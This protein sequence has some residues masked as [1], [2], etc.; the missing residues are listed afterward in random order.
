MKWI[1]I[2]NVEY[3]ECIVLGGKNSILMNDCGSMS[4]K[5]HGS[6]VIIDDS[7]ASIANRYENYQDKFFILTHY[8]KDH[9]CGMS[10]ICV[11][12]SGYFNRVFIPSMPCDERG[13]AVLLDYAIY[14]YIFMPYQSDSS[15][16]NTSCVRIF[17][18][19]SK[20]AGAERIFTL[21]RGDNFTFDGTG[22]EVL[23]PLDEKYEF[24]SELCEATEKLNL[25]FAS[26]YL[27]GPAKNFLGI[28]NRYVA[29]Y[30]KCCKAF[31]V[32][33]RLPVEARRFLLEQ[34]E[35][36]LGELENIKKDLQITPQFHDVRE[37]LDSPLAVEAYT[38]S[39]N[40]ASII[41]QNVRTRESS[42]EDIL[43][44]GDCTPEALEALWEDLYDN[45]YVVKA[46]HHGTASGYSKLFGEM[47]IS[48]LLI[49]NGEYHA[50]GKI[51]ENYIDMQN[52][53]KHCSNNRACKFFEASQS[54]CNR[55]ASCYDQQDTSGLA[56]KC[57]A[58]KGNKNL[59]GCAI[60]TV[61]MG[62]ELP[63]FCDM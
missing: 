19:L 13:N 57:N 47:G 16:V 33:E 45:Y 17:S 46:P 34:L 63:C 5:L 61:S 49:S 44:T 4:Q 25:L 41:Y 10:K 29:A 3:G 18:N 35:N 43:M 23:S 2:N 52:T 60:T 22:Y 21:K 8:H 6:E 20:H 51:A 7:F 54:C 24:S 9:L 28:K 53:I 55:L 11:D 48:H 15:Q 30:L 32:T 50:G 62:K 38:K 56:L 40:A 31:S 37:I 59:P 36:L 14:S 1:E 12:R 27:S 39:V 42:F 26:P 58:L